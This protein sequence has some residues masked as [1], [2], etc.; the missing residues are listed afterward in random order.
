MV[1]AIV[2]AEV[3]IRVVGIGA[4]ISRIAGNSIDFPN[5][6]PAAKI[7]TAKAIVMRTSLLLFAGSSSSVWVGSRVTNDIGDT[8]GSEFMDIE[9]LYYC[10][11]YFAISDIAGQ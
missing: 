11:G 5:K 2:G 8:G 4:S 1:G 9:K 3:T 7:G 6:A 10:R